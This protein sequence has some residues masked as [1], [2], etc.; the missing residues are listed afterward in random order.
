MPN[1]FANDGAIGATNSGPP[2]GA[3]GTVNNQPGGV[4]GTGASGMITDTQALAD[5][6]P[7]ILSNGALNGLGGQDQSGPAI[8]TTASQVPAGWANTIM[9][10]DGG[11]V[12]DPNDASQDQSGDPTSGTG[13]PISLALSTVDSALSYG[14]KLN[15]LPTDDA[16]GQ[17][18]AN[19]PTIPGSQSN[20]PGPYQPQQPKPQQVAQAGSMP[21]VPGNQSNSGVKP[22]QPMPGPLP[23][24]SNPFGKRADAS[25]AP[26]IPTDDGDGDD[27][28][29]ET[30]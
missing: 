25:Q 15:G 22:I 13:D 5:F 8:N 9:F 16:S 24:T 23:P 3:A 10:D 27:D 18:A 21:S 7:G 2:Q 30:S 20:T 11:S 6:G 29:T 17:Q 4:P 28:S 19:M 12:P 1:S 26:I 14:R